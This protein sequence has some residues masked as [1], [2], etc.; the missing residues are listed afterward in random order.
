MLYGIIVTCL[1]VLGVFVVMFQTVLFTDHHDD[2]NEPMNKLIDNKT[3]SKSEIQEVL[4][5]ALRIYYPTLF[6]CCVLI[7]C[8]IIQGIIWI[9]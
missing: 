6:I 5:T 9:I 7:L 8:G 2:L 1:C 3:F 4:L